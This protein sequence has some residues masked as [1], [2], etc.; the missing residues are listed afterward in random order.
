MIPRAPEPGETQRSVRVNEAGHAVV[1]AWG[2]GSLRELE[3]PPAV[4]P[5]LVSVTDRALELSPI[6]FTVHDGGRLESEQVDLVAAGAS[7]TMLSNHLEQTDGYAHA[8]DLVP[9]VRGK[10]RWEWPLIYQV[11]AAMKQAAAELEA[12]IRWGGCWQLLAAI[13]DPEEAVM[14]YLD[15][16]R[17]RGQ[18]AHADGPHYQIELAA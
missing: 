11:A 18:K 14:A 7:W 2:A 3:G 13:D 16:K 8:V 1:W 6:D 10:L 5:L 4:H 17:R 15:E 12:S 9:Y